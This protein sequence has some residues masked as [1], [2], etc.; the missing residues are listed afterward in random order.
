[1]DTDET[2]MGIRSG[3]GTK[4]V[5]R[6]GMSLRIPISHR[7]AQSDPCFIRVHPWLIRLHGSGS[8]RLPGALG[9]VGYDTLAGDGG[10]D[11]MHS[12]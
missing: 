11:K 8:E 6:T 7:V 4:S 2:R 3:K 9:A 1:M 12:T 10:M 5:H